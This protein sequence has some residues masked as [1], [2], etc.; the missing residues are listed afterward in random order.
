MKL[1]DNITIEVDSEHTNECSYKCPYLTLNDSMINI[2]DFFEMVLENNIKN[3]M[4]YRCGTYRCDKCLKR[5][6]KEV[7]K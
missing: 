3:N 4:P 6:T 2:C 5:F 7:K 1:K